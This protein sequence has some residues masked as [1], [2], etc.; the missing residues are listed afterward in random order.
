[1]HELS[2]SNGMLEI[3]EKQAAEAEFGR[4]LVVRLE[5]GSLSCVERDALAFC[6]DS[7]TR[8]SVAEGARLDI[9]PVP[10]AAWCWDCEDVV[11]LA[12][13]GEACERC[14]GY[15]LRVRD[16]EQVRIVE[17]EVA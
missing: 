17:L 9:L 13:R 14:G 11:S 8:G 5:V 4:V 7:V 15:R 1:M 16:G 10:G 12:R 6:F 3:I 2:L